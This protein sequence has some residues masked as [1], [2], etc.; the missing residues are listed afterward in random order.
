[1]TLMNSSSSARSVIA[2]IAS[3]VVA[4]A[5]LLAVVPAA[6]AHSAAPVKRCASVPFTPASDD[7]AAEIRATGVSCA[8]ARKFV[9][10]SNGRPART[11][12][13][14]LHPPPRLRTRSHAAAH[15]VPVHPRVEDDPL[16]AVLSRSGTSTMPNGPTMA[17]KAFAVT[18]P[19]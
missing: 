5:A 3:A 8:F 19:T 18:P 1:M 9:R 12:R 2:A 16:E 4:L 13:L 15:A 17:V 7:L 14:H 6:S 11:Y 10:D